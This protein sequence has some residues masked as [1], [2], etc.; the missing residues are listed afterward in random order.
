VVRAFSNTFSFWEKGKAILA[1]QRKVYDRMKLRFYTDTHIPR[2]V[3]IQLRMKGIEVV[4]CE[5]IGMAEADDESHLTYAAE[6]GLALITKDAGFRS[7]HFSG[8]VTERLIMGSSSVRIA[9]SPQSGKSLVPVHSIL[10]FL[11]QVQVSYLIFKT[12]SLT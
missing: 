2:Q 5:E 4:R 8:C 1:L 12:N 9:T 6:N 11:K 10:N 3:A 7:R